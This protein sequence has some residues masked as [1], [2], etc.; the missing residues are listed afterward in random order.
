[1]MHGTEP[2]WDVDFK[3]GTEDRPTYSVNDYCNVLLRKLEGAYTLAREHLQTTA[4]KMCDW[5]DQKV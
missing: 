5:Y 2:H 3:L 1:M 4:T